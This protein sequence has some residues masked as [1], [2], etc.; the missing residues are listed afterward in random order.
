M[1]YE[2]QAMNERV[3]REST[4]VPELQKAVQKVILGQRYLIDRLMIGILCDGH[5]LIE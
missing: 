3:E 2:V 5:I 1:D 4:F